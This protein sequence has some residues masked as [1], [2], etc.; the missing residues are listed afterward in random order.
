MGE[1]SPDV[2]KTS[3]LQSYEVNFKSGNKV[4]VSEKV[5]D[6]LDKTLDVY[7]SEGKDAMVKMRDGSRIGVS[8]ITQIRPIRKD[9]S[10][11]T[12]EN[13]MKRIASMIGDGATG[14][15]RKQWCDR[16]KANI[17][18]GKNGQAWVY[19]DKY[20]KECSQPTAK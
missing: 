4:I 6:V 10:D 14:S 2:V 20:G 13:N 19:Y 18:R 5:K 16:I 11:I 1:K 8:Q 3:T 15:V 17:E 7:W 9:A 12:M